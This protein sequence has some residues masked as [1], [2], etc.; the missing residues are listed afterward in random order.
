MAK[1]RKAKRKKRKTTDLLEIVDAR[2]YRTPAGRARLQDKRASAEV[3][4]QIYALRKEAGLTQRELAELVGTRDS[5]IS[6]L[7]D[8]D[9]RGHSLSMLRRIA[10]AVGKRIEIRF[11]PVRKVRSA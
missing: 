3:A 8:D 2:Y 6:R 7:E 11:V 5:V 1:K 10:A 9:Y 4:R